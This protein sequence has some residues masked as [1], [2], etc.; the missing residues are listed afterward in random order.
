MLKTQFLS[1]QVFKDANVGCLKQ[2]TNL[3]LGKGMQSQHPGAL[4]W[5]L[6]VPKI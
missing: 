1:K 5:P 6:C 4:S 2:G 3:P